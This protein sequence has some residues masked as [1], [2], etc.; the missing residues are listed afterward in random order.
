MI[1]ITLRVYVFIHL[2]IY[3]EQTIGIGRVIMAQDV[4][5][6]LAV[7]RYCMY[8]NQLIKTQR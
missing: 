4:I 8:Y 1:F 6:I 2:F 5:K 3:H 7:T